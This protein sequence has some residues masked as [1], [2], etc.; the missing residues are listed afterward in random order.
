MRTKEKAVLMC[1]Q[2][3]FGWIDMKISNEV[4]ALFASFYHVF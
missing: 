3:G 2:S 4:F 1:G